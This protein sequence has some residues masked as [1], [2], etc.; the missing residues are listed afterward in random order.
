MS[1]VIF[2]GVVVAVAACVGCLHVKTESVD[3]EFKSPVPPI[4]TGGSSATDPRTPY[5]DALERVLQQQD[6][7]TKELHRRDWGELVDEAGDWVEYV[8]VL[9]GYAGTSH[10][11]ARF[12]QYCD[13]LLVATQEVRRAAAAHD[14][15]RCQQ[16]I[17]ACDPVLDR[18]STTFPTTRSARGVSY[19]NTGSAP[20]TS[21]SARHAASASVS[22][23]AGSASA[24]AGIP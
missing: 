4:N 14:A 16:A 18:L 1:R 6:K 13:E 24:S 9:A 12:R 3:V 7:V 10:D 20:R 21:S 23:S 5:A 8:R 22:S 17:A 11:P 19:A 2:I 15:A